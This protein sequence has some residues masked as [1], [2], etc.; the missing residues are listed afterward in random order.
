MSAAIRKSHISRPTVFA[1]CSMQSG[2][3]LTA[4]KVKSTRQTVQEHRHGKAR[5]SVTT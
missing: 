4:K 5:R 1:A 2:S 3:P